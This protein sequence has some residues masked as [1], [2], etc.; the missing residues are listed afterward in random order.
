LTVAVTAGCGDG[1]TRAAKAYRRVAAVATARVALVETSAELDAIYD[2]LLSG[3]TGRLNLES[4]P[5][6]THRQRV[7]LNQ[8]QSL[9]IRISDAESFRV[10]ALYKRPGRA[11][12]DSHRRAISAC[13]P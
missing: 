4:G 5:R 7:V 12:S 3:R 1:T 2:C 11:L 9:L 13:A 10:V 8:P 6:F